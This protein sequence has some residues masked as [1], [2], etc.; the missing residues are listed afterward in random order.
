MCEGQLRWERVKLRC[1]PFINDV[2]V[3]TCT[4]NQRPR[5]C[6][7]DVVL[8]GFIIRMGIEWRVRHS[9]MSYKLHLPSFFCRTT[10]RWTVQIRRVCDIQQQR[11]SVGSEQHDPSSRKEPCQILHPQP[12]L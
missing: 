6:G 3:N 12:G 5:V 10:K 2:S 4:A 9:I 7:L 8:W 11:P 1:T